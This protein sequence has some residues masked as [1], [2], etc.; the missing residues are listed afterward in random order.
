MDS[1]QHKPVTV[2]GWRGCPYFARSR[3]LLES[4]PGGD[5]K[6]FPDRVGFKTWLS[7]NTGSFDSERASSHTSCP[8]VFQGERYIGGNDAFQ[9]WVDDLKLQEKN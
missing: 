5:V 9:A 7:E 4:L 6:E 8:F 3:A 2:V 1:S